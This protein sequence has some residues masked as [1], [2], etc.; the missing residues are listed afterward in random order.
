MSKKHEF[1]VAM[2]PIWADL[3]EDHLLSKALGAKQVQIPGRKAVLRGDN[4]HTLGIVSTKYGL[5]THK[6]IIDSFRKALGKEEY[7]EDI[8]LEKEGAQMFATYGLPNQEIEVG[9]GDKITMK[10]IVRNSYDGTN[11]LRITLGAYRLVCANGMMIGRKMFTFSQKHIAGKEGIDDE[12]IKEK[13][14]QVI[15][16]FYEAIPALKAMNETRA[17][18]GNFDP[19]RVRIPKY[20]LEIAREQYNESRSKTVWDYYNAL[21]WAITHR[22]KKDSEEGRIRYGH[23]AWDAATAR[24]KLPK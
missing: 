8:R 14:D 4:G 10:F 6:D 5:L 2:V 11:A 7:E 20:L 1:P 17:G 15:G 19:K 23:A 22:M 9:A 18:L 21:T 16:K 12:V 13:V 3:K 24:I